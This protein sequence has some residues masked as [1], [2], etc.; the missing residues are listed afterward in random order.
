MSD[1]T[2]VAELRE[3]LKANPDADLD[4]YE[5]E[6]EGTLSIYNVNY[7]GDSNTIQVGIGVE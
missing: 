2:W 6:D 3:Q 5:I 7:D 4:L 1:Q